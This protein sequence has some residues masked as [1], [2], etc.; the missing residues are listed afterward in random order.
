MWRCAQL[1]CVRCLLSKA[2]VLR[3]NYQ[4][5]FAVGS[6]PLEDPQGQGSWAGGH[7]HLPV[8]CHHT[9]WAQPLLGVRPVYGVSREYCSAMSS[10]GLGW[11]IWFCSHHLPLCWLWHMWRSRGGMIWRARLAEV[12]WSFFEEGVSLP[13][14]QRTVTVLQIKRCVCQLGLGKPQCIWTGM[15]FLGGEA[16]LKC[17]SFCYRL[18]LIWPS[19]LCRSLSS[20]VG[21]SRAWISLI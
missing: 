20:K 6:V 13:D 4:K 9:G 14:H 17:V 1:L 19:W 11:D 3:F 10:S 21:V 7:L 2:K 15:L 8:S 5:M 12:A 16:D 18:V